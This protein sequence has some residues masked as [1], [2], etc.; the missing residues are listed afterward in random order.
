MNSIA[1]WLFF[2]TVVPLILTPGPDAF[3]ERL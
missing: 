1:L 3:Q 2:L